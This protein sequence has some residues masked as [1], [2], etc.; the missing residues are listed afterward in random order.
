MDSCSP[1]SLDASIIAVGDSS[2]TGDV[3]TNLEY[4]DSPSFPRIN[5]KCPME[6]GISPMSELARNLCCTSLGLNP[7]KL[8]L[9][10][11]NS[12]DASPAPMRHGT[13]VGELYFLLV[14]VLACIF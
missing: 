1:P 5:V 8:S 2:Y 10:S 4:N 7:R 3:N 11:I 14:C 13:Y 9:S 6:P 12:D